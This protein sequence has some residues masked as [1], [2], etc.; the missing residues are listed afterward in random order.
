MSPL[1]FSFLDRLCARF[2]TAFLV[3]A[4]ISGTLFMVIYFL[5]SSGTS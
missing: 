4:Q 5:V 3:A 1:L 2:G